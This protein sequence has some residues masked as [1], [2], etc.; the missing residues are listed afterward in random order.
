MTDRLIGLFKKTTSKFADKNVHYLL[1]LGIF[2]E[3]SSELT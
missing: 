2:N 1:N 3:Y